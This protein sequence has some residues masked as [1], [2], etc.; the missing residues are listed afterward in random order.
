MDA[1]LNEE[2]EVGWGREGSDASTK[3]GPQRGKTGI[4]DW[5]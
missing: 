2:D 4:S 3:D 1:L 5:P